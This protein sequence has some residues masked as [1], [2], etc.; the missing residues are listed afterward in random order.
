MVAGFSPQEARGR[1]VTDGLAQAHHVAS[2]L[3]ILA[4]TGHESPPLQTHMI[5]RQVREHV[6]RELAARPGFALLPSPPD[7]LFIRDGSPGAMLS[8]ARQLRDVLPRAGASNAGELR[9]RYGL[10]AHQLDPG[11]VSG[12]VPD[13]WQAPARRLAHMAPPGGLCLSAN[14]ADGLRAGLDADLEDQ[15]LLSLDGLPEPCHVFL[16]LQGEAVSEALPLGDLRPG[17]AILP[18]SVQAPEGGYAVI[19]DLFADALVTALSRS[20]HLRIISRLSSAQFRDA[21]TDLE[22]IGERLAAAYVLTGQC[23]VGMGQRLFL[24]LQLRAVPGGALL[25]SERASCDASDL[26]QGDAQLLGELAG[27]I[28]ATILNQALRAAQLPSWHSVQD[29]S[30]ML[31]AVTLM[32]K[33]APGAY[34]QSGEILRHLCETR[35]KAVEPRV[36][37]AKWEVM[38]VTQGWTPATD[39]ARAAHG[40][41]QQALQLQADHALAL[42][43]DGLVEGFLLG[44]LDVAAK[45]YEAALQHNPNEALAWLF[46]SALHAYRDEGKRAADA[47]VNALALSP[48]DPWAYYYDSFAANAM[49]A[50]GRLRESIQLGQRSVRAR[51]NH[52]PT[53]RSLAIAQVLNHDI[54]GARLT[55]QRLLKLQPDYSLREFRQ[56]Y[57]GRNSQHMKR[58]EEALREAGLPEG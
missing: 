13:L 37:L 41:T 38:G 10:H 48:L 17:I 21:P 9:L 42:A 50:A 1:S 18:L 24:D 30:L 22:A 20:T 23:H 33:L 11:D 54:E 49:L 3:A 19:G 34:R 29:Y 7:C 25:W 57:G 39:G 56:R 45:R 26:L 46:S 15:G 2:T 36:W 31:A 16:E 58:Y 40:L 51:A 35:P 43:I 52:L 32:H 53:F 5:W 28:N 55:M 14:A 8:F 4:D 27:Q 12:E 44:N 6:E 47:A